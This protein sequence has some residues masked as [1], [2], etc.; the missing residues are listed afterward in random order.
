VKSQSP[1]VGRVPTFI[2]SHR[3]LP[4]LGSL[5]VLLSVTLGACSTDSGAD[6]VDPGEGPALVNV[7]KPVGA[8]NGWTFTRLGAGTKPALAVS[9]DGTVHATFML[10]ASSGWVKYARM[11]FGRSPTTPEIVAEGYFYGP[12]DINLAPDGR[13]SVQYHDHTQMDQILAQQQSDGSWSLDTMVNSGHDGWYTSGAFDSEGRL[14]TATYD[15]AGFEGKGVI[16]GLRDSSGWQIE[17]AA[18]GGF[19]YAGG[20]SIAL[21]ADGTVYIAFLDDGAGLG[22]I[23]RRDVDGEWSVQDIEA[24]GPDMLE[25]GRFPDLVIGS[26]GVTLH[27]TYLALRSGSEGVV[28]YATGEFGALRASDVANVGDFVI[29]FSGARDLSTLALDAQGR[30]VV[31]LQT[32]S[33]LQVL[34]LDGTGF[35]QLASFTAPDGVVFGQQTDIGI[36]GQNRTHVG[37][38]Q[39]SGGIGNVCHAVK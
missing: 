21:G 17:L 6:P 3:S 4:G 20:M 11:P 39:S 26:D 37:W 24:L 33:S 29:G 23:A 16:Y 8:A 14:H 22:K 27:L 30:P 2:E 10:E 34:R 15:P 28:R 35:E 5:A 12:I 31:A 18:G 1:A 36:D 25:V 13:P 32:Q 19:D 38:W 9:A 7:C